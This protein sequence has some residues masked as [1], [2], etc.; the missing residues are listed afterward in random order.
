MQVFYCVNLCFVSI[1]AMNQRIVGSEDE[2]QRNTT[3]PVVVDEEEDL[4]RS[5]SSG[6][7][8]VFGHS[9]PSREVVFFVQVAV[10]LVVLIT[11]VVN[12]SLV[13]GDQALWKYLMCSIVGYILPSPSLERHVHRQ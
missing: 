7:W 4:R 10:V 2:E 9:L 6:S 3:S 1:C 5:S 8:R 11:C 12:L 13:Q